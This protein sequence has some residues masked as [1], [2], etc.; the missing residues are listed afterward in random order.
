[1]F[2]CFPLI[3]V[4]HVEGKVLH[5]LCIFWGLRF[6][7]VSTSA[8]LRIFPVWNSFTIPNVQYLK[9]LS[10]NYFRILDLYSSY[11]LNKWFIVSVFLFIF[12]VCFYD[13]P[14]IFLSVVCV[15]TYV[16]TYTQFFQSRILPCHPTVLAPKVMTKML[17]DRKLEQR[18]IQLQS[19]TYHK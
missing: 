2:L 13:F 17:S 18:A 1:M 14:L 8:G 3:E 9:F 10:E 4:F 12:F 11:F 16:C 19:L 15:C 6:L 5:Y 7:I